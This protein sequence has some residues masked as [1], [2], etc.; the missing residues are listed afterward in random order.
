MPTALQ[1][2]GAGLQERQ[3]RVIASLLLLCEEVC[4]K[5][6]ILHQQLVTILNKCMNWVLLPSGN[7]WY[8]DVGFVH[9]AEKYFFSHLCSLLLAGTSGSYY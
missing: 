1:R 5:S 3:A 9:S 2:T 6:R 7:R 4:T 8:K